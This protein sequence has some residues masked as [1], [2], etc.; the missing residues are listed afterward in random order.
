LKYKI[1]E[2]KI[3]T[4]ILLKGWWYYLLLLE[5]LT[6]TNAPSAREFLFLLPGAVTLQAEPR[7][8]PC[9]IEQEIQDFDLQA[10]LEDRELRLG[11]HLPLCPWAARAKIYI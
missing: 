7:G 10:L 8:R 9:F 5:R 6:P 3:E 2:V 4:L 1:N 11:G